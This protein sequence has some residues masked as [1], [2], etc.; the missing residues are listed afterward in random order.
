MSNQRK[1]SIVFVHGIWADGSSFSKLIPSFQADGYEVIA[2]QYGLDTLAEDVAA[3]KSALGRVS[4]PAI[5]VGHSYG[6]TLITAAG[7][8]P[9][10]AGLVI[11]RHSRRT[12]TRPRRASRPSSRS[13]TSFH[14]SK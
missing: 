7:T 4:S 14:T 6:G 8:D 13:R 11:S 9:R 2:A 12:S 1:P 10:V 5:L 3:V